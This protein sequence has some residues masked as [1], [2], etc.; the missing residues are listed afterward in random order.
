[1]EISQRLWELRLAGVGSL[2]GI[3]VITRDRD[4]TLGDVC[5]HVTRNVA[6]GGQKTEAIILEKTAAG[7]K[8]LPDDHLIQSLW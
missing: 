8:A 1:M 3:R 5:R 6:T 2:D 4:E 7:F